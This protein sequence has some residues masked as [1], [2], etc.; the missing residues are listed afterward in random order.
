MLA[1]KNYSALNSTIENGV[2]FVRRPDWL[3][4]NFMISEKHSVLCLLKMEFRLRLRRD[5]W[6]IL[7]SS[8]R[9]FNPIVIGQKPAPNCSCLITPLYTSLLRCR[10][11]PTSIKDHKISCVST[12]RSLLLNPLRRCNHCCHRAQAFAQSMVRIEA[13]QTQPSYQLH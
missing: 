5:C 8:K 2:R 6:N 12:Q 11:R 13:H 4:L 9:M 10:K 3:T 1:K 7:H